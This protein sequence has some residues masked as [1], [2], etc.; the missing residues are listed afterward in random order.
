MFNVAGRMGLGTPYRTAPD[1]PPC[2]MRVLLRL[3]YVGAFTRG[4]AR[5]CMH[6]R[7]SHDG[8]ETIS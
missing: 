2:I 6:A 7:E 5:V 8:R 1:T 4:E 3:S